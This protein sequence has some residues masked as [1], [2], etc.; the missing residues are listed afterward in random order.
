MPASVEI[1]VE[2]ATPAHLVFRAAGRILGKPVP[3]RSE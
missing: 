3:Q 2:H 1:D